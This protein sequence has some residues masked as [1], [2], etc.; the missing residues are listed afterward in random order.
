V[1]RKIG[2]EEAQNL[3][4]LRLEWI[5]IQDESQRH[6][7]KGT[8]AAHVLGSVDF[9]EKGNAGIEQVLDG[10]TARP[11]GAGADAH[12]REAPGHR[13]AVGFGYENR[14]RR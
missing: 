2:Y 5:H 11:G 10:G 9:E 12:G 14:A 8:L 13:F 6:Y 4:N 7:P 1:K 3:R